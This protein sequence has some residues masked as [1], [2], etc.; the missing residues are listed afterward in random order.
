MSAGPGL[1]PDG[2]VAIVTGAAGGIGAAVAQRLLEGGAGVV[3][4]DLDADRL[5]VSVERLSSVGGPNRVTGVSG[6][7]S[8]EG[9]IAALISAAEES[10]GPVDLFVANAGIGDGL[11]LDADDYQWA[12]VMDVNLMAHVRAA[13]LLVPGWVERGRGYFASTASAAGLLTQIGSATYT[14]SKHGAVAF[15]EW[16]AVTYG[17]QGVGVSC[18]CPMGVDTDLLRSGMGADDEGGRRAIAAVTGAGEVLDPVTVA[19]DLL[20]A[21]AEGRFLVTPHANVPE[22]LRR[23][24]DD[25]DRWIQGMQRYAASL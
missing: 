8:D 4:S 18:L 19:D 6:D 9:V 10:F 21:I 22:L 13:R 5:A 2:A 15:A 14:V 1:T 7:A 16:L 3:V 20:A 11:G 23:K 25:R 12:T 17:A 24:V